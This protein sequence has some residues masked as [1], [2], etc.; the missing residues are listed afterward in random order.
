MP[1]SWTRSALKTVSEG[2][3]AGA[4]PSPGMSAPVRAAGF[5]ALL[6]HWRAVRRLS[7]LELS[8][9]TGVSTRYLS[10]LET[11]RS[12]PSRQIVVF[13]AE[14]LGVPLR[15]RNEL[16][17]SAGFAPS[18]GTRNLDDPAMSAV[19]DSISRLLAAHEPY[20]A[21][22]MDIRWNRLLANE[23]ARIFARGVAPSLLADPVNVLRLTLHPEGM[24]PRIANLADWSAHVLRQV[25]RRAALTGDAEIARL[26]DELAGYP[27]VMRPPAG[28]G[29]RA[30]SRRDGPG[31]DGPGAD[32]EQ[33]VLPL[34]YRSDDQVLS[35]LNT[36]TSF[37]APLDAAL[38]EVVID[39]LYPADEPTRLALLR[40]ARP[41]PDG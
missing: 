4:R 12:Q 9:A 6:R 22:V 38:S 31:L 35:F 26:Y 20:P 1:P 32:G 30:G 34:R 37:G 39:S 3:P 8:A 15:D 41:L 2:E 14:E 10:F 36:T 24:A 7:Q 17:M 25:R 16:L 18:Y 28:G 13:L 5:G 23:G 21:L 33:V 40:A 11:G 19:R 27:G 29:R